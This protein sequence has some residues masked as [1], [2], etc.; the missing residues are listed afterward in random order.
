[1]LTLTLN[2]TPRL[3]RYDAGRAGEELVHGWEEMS[4]LNLAQLARARDMA[5]K[6][7]LAAGMD[8]ATS[9]RARS[10]VVPQ[11][12]VSDPKLH[13]PASVRSAARSSDQRLHLPLADEMQDGVLTWSSSSVAILCHTGPVHMPGSV[14]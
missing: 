1:M 5:A 6:L 12:P 4:T 13:M 9:L 11:G 7:V 10:L 8:D 14:T 2:P 3:A